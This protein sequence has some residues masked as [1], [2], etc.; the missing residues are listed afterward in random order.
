MPSTPYA[1]SAA[2][3]PIASAKRPKRRA[4]HAINNSSPVRR[5]ALGVDVISATAKGSDD[6][7]A[8]GTATG[9]GGR[10]SSCEEGGGASTTDTKINTTPLGKRAEEGQGAEVANG[11][12]EAPS[13]T[14]A[15]KGSTSATPRSSGLCD[16]RRSQQQGEGGGR[17]FSLGGAAEIEGKRLEGDGD[18]QDQNRHKPKESSIFSPALNQSQEEARDQAP[19]STVGAEAAAAVVVTEKH[20]RPDGDGDHVGAAHAGTTAS[21]SSAVAEPLSKKGRTASPSPANRQGEGGEAAAAAAPS[22]GEQGTDGAGEKPKHGGGIEHDGAPGLVNREDD[23]QGVDGVVEEVEVDVE[24]EED[25]EEFNPY[26]FIAHLPP[27]NTVKHHTPEAPALPEK[28]KT[29]HGKELT[30][31]LDLDE[32]LVHCTVD[33]IVNPDHRFEVH[34]NGEEFQVYVRKRPHLDAFLEAVSELFEVVVFTASQQVYAER[35]LNMIDPQ[36]KFVKYRLYRDACMALE[37]NYLKDLNVLGRDL[38]KVAI[39]DNSPYAYG[40][41]IDNGI[42][43]ESWFDDKSDEELLHLL[44]LLKQ[45]ISESETAGGDVRPFIRNIFKTHELVDKARNGDRDVGSPSLAPAA[46]SNVEAADKKREAAAPAAAAA[47]TGGES[48]GEDDALTHAVAAE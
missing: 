15:R 22:T 18:H 41:Q 31:V 28:R 2:A 19:A 45:L 11:G 21:S 8:A 35:L 10:S 20:D 17:S 13:P 32:T 27:Y 26:C 39:V 40:F 30:L 9:E 42:P 1:A 12:P 33:P 48:K 3:T 24:E 43:I 46:S 7:S 23:G 25:E 29:R 44:P 47:P 38:S 37:G 16:S 4:N 6:G 36:K 14:K 5:A 34:F